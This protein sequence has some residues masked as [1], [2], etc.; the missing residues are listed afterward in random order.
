MNN[1]MTNRS[2]KA[3]IARGLFFIVVLL[4]SACDGG[5]FGTGGPDNIDMSAST[6]ADIPLTD[7]GV[8]TTDGTSSSESEAS[9]DT[10][11]GGTANSETGSTNGLA[12]ASDAGSTDAGA[13]DGGMP[14]ATGDSTTGSSNTGDP[15]S[16]SSIEDSGEFINNQASLDPTTITTA[17]INVINATSLSVNII[18]TGAETQPE[19]SLFGVSGVAANTLSGSAALL[20]NETSLAIT[21]NATP[22]M[23]VFSFTNFTADDATFSTLLVRE[24]D[25]QID[26][27]PLITL[28]ATQ[29]ETIAKVRVLQAIP[30]SDA[31]AEALINLQSAGANPGGIDQAFGPLSYV[32]PTTDYIDIPSGDYEL[33]D[34]LGRFENQ[35]LTFIGSNVYTVV[36]MENSSGPLLV[37]NDTESAVQ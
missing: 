23:T 17:R 36:L 34:S 1:P 22:A 29:D 4:L 15:T 37:I 18:E 28:T 19:F 27:V 9:T 6:S 12:E 7:S 25:S 13:A 31:S 2:T 26:A 24:N 30:F 14:P 32:N 16:G 5:I 21:D 20:E 8:D 11:A 33:I 10:S 35:M 3:G